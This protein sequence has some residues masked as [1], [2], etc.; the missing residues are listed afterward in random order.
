[1]SIIIKRNTGWLGVASKIQIKLNG[2]RAAS[3]K[4]KEHIEIEIPEGKANL[5]VTQFT[6]NSN[7]ITVKDGDIIEITS[8]PF[9]R[10]SVPLIVPILFLVNLI[11]NLTYRL[12][13]SGA[14]FALI[15]VS[16]FYFKIFNLR[17]VANKRGQHP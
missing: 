13:I 2:Q 15:V 4:E 9:Y 14:F 8:T 7:K 6:A 10:I 11:P 3:I 17:V 12:I 16:Q 1:M 5:K